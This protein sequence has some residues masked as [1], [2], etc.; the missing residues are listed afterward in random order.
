MRKSKYGGRVSRFVL[1]STV[2]LT[3]LLGVVGLQLATSGPAG[4]WV[5]SSDVTLNGSIECPAWGGP[6]DVPTWVWVQGNTGDQG[7]A[8][9]GGG[10]SRP[11]SFNLTHVPSGHAEQVQVRVGCSV[12]GQHNANFGVQRPLVGSYATVNITF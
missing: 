8:S 1:A 2:A 9:L 12:T 11:Y 5:W 4:A 7:W 10:Y 6:Y 3:G